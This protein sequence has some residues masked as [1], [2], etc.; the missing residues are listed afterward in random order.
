MTLYSP[1][2]HH[3]DFENF[4]GHGMISAVCLLDLGLSSR[5]WRLVHALHPVM[6]GAVFGVFSLVY[7]LAGGTNYFYEPY[8]YPI[9][10]WSRPIRWIEE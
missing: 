6:F 3:L 1:E 2:R 5:P 7:H 8:I 4:S 10:D 9:L